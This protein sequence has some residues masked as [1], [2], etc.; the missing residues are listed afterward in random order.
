MCDN[1]NLYVFLDLGHTPPADEFRTKEG[2][3]NPVIYFPLRIAQCEECGLTQLTHVVD[4]SLLFQNDYP[5]ESSI[6]ATGKLHWKKFAASVITKVNLNTDSLVVDIGSNVGVLLGAFKNAGMRVQGIDPAPNIVEIANNNGI[7]TLCDFMTIKSA[8]KVLQEKGKAK[9]ITGTNVFAHVDDLNEFMISVLSLLTDDGVFIFES[10]YFVHLLNNNEYDTIY[11]EHLSYISI[12]P[13][14]PFFARFGMEIFEIEESSIHG[15]SIR[16]YVG[17]KGDRIVSNKI[18]EFLNLELENRIYSKERLDKFSCQVAKN[19]KD[20]IALLLKLTS[21]GNKI[22]AVSAPAKG[23]TLLNYCGLGHH[24]LDFVTEKSTLKIGRYTPG[25]HIPVVDDE[26]LLNH[27]PD[28]ALVLA[29]NFAAEIIANLDEYRQR[30][31]KFII[32]IPTPTI[33]E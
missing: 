11:H 22:V 27:Q 12:K 26:Q 2:L 25:T 5:Y 14:I 19:R 31:G 15:G 1:S 9:I 6:T 16:V 20:L 18:S 3:D 10:P 23:M 4:P 13:L 33:I 24:I 28:Y 17:K 21:E 7:D 29:W 32:P 30:G 8:K